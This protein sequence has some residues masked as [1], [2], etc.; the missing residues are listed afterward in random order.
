[1]KNNYNNKSIIKLINIYNQ[2]LYSQTY[3]INS[4]KNILTGELK[5]HITNIKIINKFLTNININK[6]KR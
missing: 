4:I 2:Y 5:D 3:N 6:K 1:M